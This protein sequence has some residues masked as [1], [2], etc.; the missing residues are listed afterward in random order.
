MAIAAN[1][2]EKIVRKVVNEEQ[3]ETTDALR[4]LMTLLTE[5]VIP[6]LSA[7]AGDGDE[8]DVGDD[9]GSESDD[10]VESDDDESM[11]LSAFEDDDTTSFGRRGKPNGHGS[12]DED[13][14]SPADEDLPR[15]ALDAF[16]TL[17]NSLTSEQASALAEFF[18]VVDTEIDDA[19]RGNEESERDERRAQA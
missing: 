16:T 17:Y 14:E 7:G 12:H 8:I 1:Q 10:D 11:A 19:G 18:T 6:R 13:D 9:T 5:Q 3:S 15:A 2:I 4:E